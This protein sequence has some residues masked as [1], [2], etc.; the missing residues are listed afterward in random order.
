MFVQA[1]GG[2]RVECC[3]L[4]MLA[5]GVALLED[6]RVGMA[7]LDVGVGFKALIL[8]AWKGVFH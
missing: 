6:M 1:Y 3:G 2:Q 7:L 8:A 4:N 5:Q